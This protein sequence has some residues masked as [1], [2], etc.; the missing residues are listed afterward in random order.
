MDYGLRKKTLQC[1]AETAVQLTLHFTCLCLFYHIHSTFTPHK[2]QV[3][4]P[5]SAYSDTPG[6]IADI[7]VDHQCIC[8]QIS[9]AAPVS[10]IGVVAGP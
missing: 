4:L 8:Y 2:H 9:S 7:F 1:F 6:N 3:P 5:L 10:S